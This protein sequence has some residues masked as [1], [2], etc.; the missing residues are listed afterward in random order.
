MKLSLILHLTLSKFTYPVSVTTETYE[1]ASFD[2]YL[3]ASL[4]LHE[5]RQR[6]AYDYID[7]LVGKGS[8]NPA[9]KTLYDKLSQFSDETLQDILQNN[10]FPVRTV[11]NGNAIDFYPDLNLSTFCGQA[12]EG[13]LAK[14]PEEAQMKLPP[15]NGKLVEFKIGLGAERTGIN[16]Y[17]VHFI[18]DAIE[19][20]LF[21]GYFASMSNT[22]FNAAFQ[23]KPR[24]L[25]EF[26]G[27]YDEASSAED[28]NYL[29]AN[30]REEIFQSK[31]FLFQGAYYRVRMGL[32][33]R[34]HF[35]FFHQF[36][37]YRIERLKF[38]ELSPDLANATL[39][40]LTESGQ[41][42]DLSIG[43]L[44]EIFP[45]ALP[46]TVIRVFNALLLNHDSNEIAHY[47]LT[48]MTPENKFAWSHEVLRK[49]KDASSTSEWA[50]IYQIDP[51]LF[52]RKELHYLPN[53]ILSPGDKAAVEAYWHDRQA[54]IDTIINI[55]GQIDASAVRT[56]SKRL[57]SNKDVKALRKL[58]N[59]YQAHNDSDI[60]QLTD[61]ELEDRLAKAHDAFALYRRVKLQIEALEKEK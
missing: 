51:E 22:A 45:R 42:A 26:N 41:I 46:D 43:D 1:K 37:I 13:D 21:P 15:L 24:V 39:R 12:V 36:Y 18:D 23:D 54:K 16:S 2:Q 40:F 14:R 5:K 35:V 20:E 59:N 10:H 33:Y 53:A 60:T 44:K 31:S 34:Y 50:K 9:F 19:I 58:I 25:S 57:E 49:C 8:L 30:S 6:Y 11:N 52:Q 56:T 28:W 47:A 61:E 38:S 48:F 32:V 4:V 27:T 7:D 55:Y 3:M 29:D 17:T